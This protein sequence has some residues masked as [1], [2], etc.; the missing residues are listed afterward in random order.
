MPKKVHNLADELIANGMPE[1]K[2]WAI[3]QSKLGKG[4]VKS[5]KK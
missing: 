2:A 4:K 1:P 3:A 5:K